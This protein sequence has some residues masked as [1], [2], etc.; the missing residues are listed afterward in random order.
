MISQEIMNFCC[1]LTMTFSVGIGIWFV[2]LGGQTG[3]PAATAVERVYLLTGLLTV[4]QDMNGRV[5][6]VVRNYTPI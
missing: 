4:H 3:L 2:A 6:T 1:R 5:Q